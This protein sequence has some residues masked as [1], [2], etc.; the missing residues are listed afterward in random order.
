MIRFLRKTF[1]LLQ[2]LGHAVPSS[3]YILLS[4]L[5]FVGLEIVFFWQQ[6]I[7]FTLLVLFGLLTIGIVLLRIEEAHRF[8]PSQIILPLLT[9]AGLSGLGLFLPVRSWLHLYFLGASLLF[10]WLLRHGAR[11]AYPTWNWMLSTATILLLV[12][13]ILGWQFHLDPPFLV[14]LIFIWTIIF[15]IGYQSLVRVA[16]YVAEAVMLALS[17]SFVLTQLA[18]VLAFLPL[19]YLVRAGTIAIFYY[20]GFHLAQVSYERRLTKRD[21]LEYGSIGGLTLLVLLSTAK[22]F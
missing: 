9:A 21:I 13:T 15:L 18:W 14:I 1:I 6:A 19:H 10:F 7:A 17:I 12:G 5:F 16:P 20:V 2:R 8:R 4:A 3:H 11:Q 22:W